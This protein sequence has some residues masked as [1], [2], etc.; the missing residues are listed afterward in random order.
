[1]PLFH[2]AGLAV[3]QNVRAAPSRSRGAEVRHRLPLAPTRP[4]TVPRL[5]CAGPRRSR[6]ANAWDRADRAS[7]LRGTARSRPLPRAYYMTANLYCV[8]LFRTVFLYC[9][10]LFWHCSWAIPRFQCAEAPHA[11]YETV[12]HSAKQCPNTSTVFNSTQSIK[13]A[14]THGAAY[15]NRGTATVP[16]F[17]AAEPLGLRR[18]RVLKLRDRCSA[19]RPTAGLTVPRFDAAGP[20]RSRISIPRDEYI[21]TKKFH[22]CI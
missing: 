6:V 15:W 11:Q 18:S 10:S 2:S 12:L 8:A 22:A 1:M 21:F 17:G 3:A 4:E 16:R 19:T 7:R 9:L 20:S 5:R 13:I 14:S